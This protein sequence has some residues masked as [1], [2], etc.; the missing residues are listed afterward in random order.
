VEN[1]VKHRNPG[2]W[3]GKRVLMTGNTGF[4]GSWLSLWLARKG[5]KLAGYSLRPTQSDDLFSSAHVA[6]VC[7]TTYADIR[8]LE[9]LKLAIV[10]FDPQVIFHLAAQPI[11]R[12]SYEDP[13][14]TLSTNLMG[15]CNLLDTCRSLQN[16]ESIVVIASDKCY[17]NNSWAWGYRECDPL[18]GSDP[19]SASK[20]AAEIAVESYRQSY[21]LASGIGLASARGGNVIGG[22][23]FAFDRL[24]PDIARA[25][26][27]QTVLRLRYPNS[28]RPWQHV[29]DCLAGYLQIAEAV[30]SDRSSF[31]KAFNI[32]PNPTNEISVA[33]ITEAF[34]LLLPIECSISD[35][36]QPHE[37]ST[38]ALDSGL[39][40]QMLGW[41]P[42]LTLEETLGWTVSWYKDYFDGACSRDLVDRQISEY[43]QK[44]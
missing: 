14:G 7:E 23:D 43:E 20:A 18:G 41:K 36:T 38:L 22:G 40:K 29:L 10:H 2:F 12:Q 37:A 13:L 25:Y 15:T 16:L 3:R 24:V 1:L 44:S 6:D 27:N 11:V 32:G 30:T 8:D 5:A 17:R 28:T 34:K 31:S 4:K 19:Y 9:S 26:Q 21:Y 42:K 33:E 35:E 39:A